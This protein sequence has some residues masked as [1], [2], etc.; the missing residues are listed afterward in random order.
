[1][2]EQES[3]EQAIVDS[4]SIEEAFAELSPKYREVVDLI[5]RHGCTYE[6]TGNILDIPVGT[7]KSR[8]NA[9]RQLLARALAGVDGEPS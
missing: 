1:M 7:V 2:L 5:F 8:L 6:E 9:A 4:L 3:P